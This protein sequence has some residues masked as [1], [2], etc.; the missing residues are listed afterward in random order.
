MTMAGLDRPLSFLPIFGVYHMET[1]YKVNVE[2][3]EAYNLVKDAHGRWTTRP[4]LTSIL[5]YN[6]VNKLLY[7]FS[8]K[9]NSGQ[10]YHYIF[11][12]NTDNTIRCDLYLD[13][14][15]YLGEVNLGACLDTDA[16][17]YHAINY[18]QIIISSPGWTSPYYCHIGSTPKLADKQP[19]INPD[20]PELD[21]Y[22]GIVASFEDRF[23]WIY[24]HIANIN[25]PG[26]DPRVIT[27]LTAIS[28]SGPITDCFQANDGMLYIV[29]TNEIKTLPPDGLAGA[30]LEGSISSSTGYFGIGYRNAIST[31]R[32]V[33]GLSSVGLINLKTGDTL[34]LTTY[35]RNRKITEPVG[36]GISTDFRHGKMFAYDEGIIITFGAGKPFCVINQEKSYVSW[37][38]DSSANG[39]IV[40]L[41]KAGD[42]TP[43]LVFSNG[44]YSLFGDNANCTFGLACELPLD[45]FYS[46]N[47][48]EI[49]ITA[50][51][52][53]AGSVR[54]YCRGSDMTSTSPFAAGSSQE[55]IAL[56]DSATLIESEFASSEHKRSVRT[57]GV[58][59]EVGLSR[60]MTL[61]SVNVVTRGQGATRNRG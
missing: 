18:N 31:R 11:D 49:V 56:W 1:T 21:L 2:A 10:T 5:L 39:N 23:V 60:G 53:G 54:S 25:E 29:S 36:V 33:F 51:G 9:S 3:G 22:P 19:S 4:A 52:M 8:A 16:P 50:T 27:A 30:R 61:Q 58:Y 13:N 28:C 38:E 47:I 41:M 43:L 44:V 55:S 35:K 37:W 45:G 57:D 14:F 17:V 7:A 12:L 40:G 26:I 20:F 42:G 24:K 46:H 48:A 34:P 59:F 32:G 15:V 6:N